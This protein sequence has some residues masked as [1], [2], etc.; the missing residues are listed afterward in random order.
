MKQSLKALRL[1]TG[2]GPDGLYARLLNH[3]NK[4]V[5]NLLL[6]TMQEVT[7]YESKSHEMSKRYLILIDKANSN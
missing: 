6:E 1:G 7:T 3:I 2:R 5:P 4:V